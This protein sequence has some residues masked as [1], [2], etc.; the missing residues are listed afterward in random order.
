MAGPRQR[1]RTG[2]QQLG[3]LGRRRGLR[4][5][6]QRVG[7]PACGACRRQVNGSLARLPQDGDGFRVALARAERSTWCARAAAL[8]PRAASAWRT[9][10]GRRAASRRA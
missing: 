1:T 9:A 3:P 6:A 5:E 10:R 4:E 8:A 2:E 7:E